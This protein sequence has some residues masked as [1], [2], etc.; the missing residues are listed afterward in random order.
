M[1]F[2]NIKHII[3]FFAVWYA[4]CA[5]FVYPYAEENETLLTKNITANYMAVGDIKYN[6]KRIGASTELCAYLIYGNPPDTLQ[7][8]RYK[9]LLHSKRVLRA[10]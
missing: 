10:E 5:P 6:G 4:V 7:V 9:Y 2:F 3:A 8:T 1:K